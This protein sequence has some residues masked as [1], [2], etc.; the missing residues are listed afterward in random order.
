MTVWSVC[1]IQGKNREGASMARQ[2]RDYLA[3]RI[4]AALIGWCVSDRTR[5]SGKGLAVAGLL[6]LLGSAPDSGA[7]EIAAI[8]NTQTVEGTDLV[9]HVRAQ[10]QQETMFTWELVGGN[11][12][13][14]V[15]YEIPTEG[16]I[17]I[18]VGQSDSQI[19]VPTV[20][21]GEP[22]SDETVVVVLSGGDWTAVA[23]GTIVDDDAT[24][25]LTW[26]SPLVIVEAAW[27]IFL[28]V[29]VILS[30]CRIRYGIASPVEMRGL[31][32]PRGSVRAV[33]ALFAVGSFVIVIVFG[34]PVIG[35]YYEIV[36]AAFGSLTGSIIGF[37]FGNRG[38][39]TAPDGQQSDEVQKLIEDVGG[40]FG[41]EGAQA[42]GVWIRLNPGGDLEDV[43]RAA[44]ASEDVDE[45][46]QALGVL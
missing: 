28:L 11:A 21:D 39:S 29:L 46:K 13:V 12:T 41:G 42:V 1:M 15:D 19:S 7:Q 14:G 43:R 24:S 35:E 40:Q 16:T 10:S 34:G 4:C 18:P 32:L 5:H 31:N 33:L 45:F 20:E 44:D 22:E 37:Y 2:H 30:R 23:V 8:S 17:T 38:A 26:E 27:I 9:F 6:A 25:G 36:L 3:V